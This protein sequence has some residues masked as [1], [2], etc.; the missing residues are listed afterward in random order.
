MFLRSVDFRA[1]SGVAVIQIAAGTY[2][3]NDLFSGDQQAMILNSDDLG[4]MERRYRAAFVNSLSGFKAA[5]LV[6]TRDPDGNCNLAIMSSAVHLGSH[7]PLLALVLRPDD[8]GQHTLA[9]I[10]DSGVYSLNHVGEAFFKAAHQTAARYPRGTSEFGEVGLTPLFEAGFQAPFVAESAIRIG[11]ELRE[12]HKLAIN[13]TNLVIGEIVLVDL[14]GDS[15][16]EDG[17]V[18][19][20]SAGTITLSGLD[21]YHRVQGLGRQP[22]AKPGASG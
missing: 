6:G 21:S 13:G 17:S 10:L 9:N 22:Y 19:I 7:P 12:H 15:I 20:A 11:L 8:A 5:N 16:E 14:P 4:K 2:K 18:D 3:E 1:R